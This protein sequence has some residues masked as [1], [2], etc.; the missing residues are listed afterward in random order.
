MGAH[1]AIIGALLLG[2]AASVLAVPPVPVPALAGYQARGLVS[3]CLACTVT[4]KK[5]NDF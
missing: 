1:E 3:R 4:V 5:T 2:N